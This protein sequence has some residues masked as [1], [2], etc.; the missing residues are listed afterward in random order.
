[1]ATNTINNNNNKT[2]TFLQSVLSWYQKKQSPSHTYPDH[3]PSFISFLHLLQSIA[4]SPF[5][6][7]AWQSFCTTSIQVLF[8]LPLVLEPP[9]HT[10]YSIHFFTQSMF[11]FRN[12]C[13]YHCNLFCCSTEIM[14][15]IP[16]HSLNSSLGA[17]SFTWTSHSH[18]TILIS[19]C[20]SATSFSFLTG[21]FS[22]Q[23]NILLC[24]Q[25]LYDLPLILATNCPNLFQPIQIMVSTAASASPSTLNM[26]PK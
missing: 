8:G 24:R 22:L 12:T 14:S 25:L 20:W 15:F 7:R 6:L 17:L 5:N 13:L 19:A 9:L 10:P 1:M 21:Q 2:T 18:L 26:L 23:C 4:S 11:S 3:Q 16:S